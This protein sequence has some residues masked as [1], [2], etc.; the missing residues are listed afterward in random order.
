MKTLVWLAGGALFV[1]AALSV[2][3]AFRSPDFVAGLAAIGAAAVWKALSP[4]L[5]RDFSP[6]HAAKVREA[7]RR[8]EPLPSRIGPRH[9]GEQR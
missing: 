6:E 3:W 4:A 2:F 1:A 9:P 8:G 7:T 5:A